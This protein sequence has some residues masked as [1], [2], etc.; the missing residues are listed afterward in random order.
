MNEIFDP[1]APYQ[2]KSGP[3]STATAAHGNAPQDTFRKIS[4]NRNPPW[5]LFPI[6]DTG[7]LLFEKLS[8]SSGTQPILFG[9]IENPGLI[10][11]SSSD[12][13]NGGSVM[14]V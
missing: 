9:E 5:I 7:L 1:S 8:T 14:P 11:G 4:G 12:G 10:D 3:R 13:L 6:K 2:A